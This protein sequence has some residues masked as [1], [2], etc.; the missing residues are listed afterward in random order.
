MNMADNNLSSI[1]VSTG[2]FYILIHKTILVIELFLCYPESMKNVCSHGQFLFKKEGVMHFKGLFTSIRNRRSLFFVALSIVVFL[3]L[4]SCETDGTTGC[5]DLECV[6]FEDLTL[7][8]VFNFM[9]QFKDSG[10]CIVASAFQWN[11]DIWTYAGFAQVTVD[12]NAGGTGQEMWCNNVTL[13]FVF[14][15]Q[16]T[17]LT[18]KFGEYGGNLNL[19]INDDFQNF[20]N[21]E[22]I[23]G[24]V[25]GGVTVTVSGDGDGQGTGTLTLSGTIDYFRIGGQELYIDD[26][27]PQE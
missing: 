24:L 5:G 4:M 3:C 11:N 27:C 16:L 26:V 8:D 10:I 7:D 12:G 17:G 6:D 9:E 14:C 18:L 19:M 25:I 13:I 1:A 20:E 15:R 2:S 22:E 21:F 23:N